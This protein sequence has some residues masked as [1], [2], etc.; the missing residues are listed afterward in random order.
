MIGFI[1]DQ[2]SIPVQGCLCECDDLIE[3]L[4]EKGLERSVSSSPLSTVAAEADCKT[5]G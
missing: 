1:M 3:K 4:A 5:M 2:L